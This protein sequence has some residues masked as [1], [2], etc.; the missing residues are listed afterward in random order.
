MGNIIPFVK[1]NS[2]DILNKLDLSRY[3]FRTERE[4][5]MI[6]LSFTLALIEDILRE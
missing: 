1:N 6:R 4:R 2:V 3:R 5:I